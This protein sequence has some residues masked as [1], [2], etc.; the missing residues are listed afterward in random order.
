MSKTNF[1][2]DPNLLLSKFT[3]SSI[4]LWNGFV[5]KNEYKKLY[6]DEWFYGEIIT[7]GKK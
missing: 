5:E 1:I 3:K 2:G 7:I 4:S 6:L